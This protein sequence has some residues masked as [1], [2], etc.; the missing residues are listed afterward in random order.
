MKSGTKQIWFL[1]VLQ[2]IIYFLLWS[3]VCH[4]IASDLILVLPEIKHEVDQTESLPVDEDIKKQLV[5]ERQV[6]GIG[7]RE[8]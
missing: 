5:L 3:F 7:E 1:D 6:D 8:R 4:L 2:V